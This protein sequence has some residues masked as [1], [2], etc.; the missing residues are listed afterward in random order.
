MITVWRAAT[1]GG[2]RIR[3][4]PHR[5]ALIPPTPDAEHCGLRSGF[6][7]LEGHG[8]VPRN[9]ADCS[10]GCYRTGDRRWRASSSHRGIKVHSNQPWSRRYVQSS[11]SE[12]GQPDH[13]RSQP[14]EGC[15]SSAFGRLLQHHSRF[16]GRRSPVQAWVCAEVENGEG[17]GAGGTPAPARTSPPAG[18]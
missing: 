2:R 6:R 14:A 9:T 3:R 8:S 17:A 16:N 10:G 1:A 11:V 7:R 13:P 5:R 12:S 15:L 18:C 4:G